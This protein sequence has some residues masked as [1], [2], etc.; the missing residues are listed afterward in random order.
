MN[1]Q[2]HELERIILWSLNKK[3]EQTINTLSK[4]TGL[5][6]PSIYRALLWLGS[7][8]LINLKEEVIELVSLDINGQAY[9]SK[10]FPE[11]R[12]IKLIQKGVNKILSIRNL[13]SNE[14]FNISIGLLKNHSHYY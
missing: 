2:L 7:K 10:G 9:L 6:K 4:N 1:N 3:E 11:K 13:L 8:K 14:E 12:L 5:D